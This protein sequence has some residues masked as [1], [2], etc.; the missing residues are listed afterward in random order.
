L[1]L[2]DLGKFAKTG[3]SVLLMGI[4]GGALLPPLLGFLK[5]S[6]SYHSVYCILSPIYCFFLFYVLKGHKLR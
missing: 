4:T 6:Y 5:D 1:A 3:S 2:A